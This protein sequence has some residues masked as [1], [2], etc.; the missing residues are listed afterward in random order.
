VRL[1]L[2]MRSAVPLPG[3]RMTVFKE[4]WIQPE[5][6]DCDVMGHQWEL[7]EYITG[8]TGTLKWTCLECEEVYDGE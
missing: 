5:L 2:R 1:S 4:R 6:Y 8:W 7:E 3:T